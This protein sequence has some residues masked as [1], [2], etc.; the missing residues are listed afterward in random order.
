M[1]LF[2]VG[3]PLLQDDFSFDTDPVALLESIKADAAKM[4]EETGWDKISN[5]SDN[6]EADPATV[7]EGIR[8]DIATLSQESGWDGSKTSKKDSV[9]NFSE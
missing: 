6:P 1:S 4:R 2:N 3:Q 7:L 9:W 5:V 8:T